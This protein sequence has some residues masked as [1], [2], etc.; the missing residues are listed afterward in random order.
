[1]LRHELDAQRGQ[2]VSEDAYQLLSGNADFLVRCVDS[3]PWP[4]PSS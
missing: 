1:M 3:H 2:Q 4:G